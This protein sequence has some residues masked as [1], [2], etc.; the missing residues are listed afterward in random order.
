[1]TPSCPKPICGKSLGATPNSVNFLF[2]GST[3]DS[4]CT[5]AIFGCMHRG[6]IDQK[7]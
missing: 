7:S 2:R 3:K 5:E 4:S 1:M 6:K